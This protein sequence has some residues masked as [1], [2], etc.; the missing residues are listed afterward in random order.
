[1]RGLRARLRELAVE[2][3][4]M[5]QLC[6][7]RGGGARSL[8]VVEESMARV[9]SALERC[10]DCQRMLLFPLYRPFAEPVPTAYRPL[11]AV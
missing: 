1:M 3:H 11:P 8:M 4:E 9:G 6:A 7:R 2:V 10:L 5:A